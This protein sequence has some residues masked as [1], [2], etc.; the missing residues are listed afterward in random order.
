MF[1]RLRV[2]FLDCITNL[3]IDDWFYNKMINSPHY[4]KMRPYLR[5]DYDKRKDARKCFLDRK[6]PVYCETV[7]HNFIAILNNVSSSGVFINTENPLAIGQE[8]AI[9]WDFPDSGKAVMAT[10]EVVRNEA[11][12]SGICIKIFFNNYLS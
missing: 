3:V 10:G 7:D 11:A 9:R 4:S 12:G 6:I 1:S 2:P 5:F 8:I